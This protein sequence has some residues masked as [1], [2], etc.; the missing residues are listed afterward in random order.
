VYESSRTYLLR[1]PN[2]TII[3]PIMHFLKFQG[4]NYLSNCLQNYMHV[5]TLNLC[6][7]T[8]I[9]FVDLY[10]IAHI[11]FLLLYLFRI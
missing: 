10:E 3:S 1:E 6:M 4:V 5:H 8:P 11:L 2:H 7:H 9:I